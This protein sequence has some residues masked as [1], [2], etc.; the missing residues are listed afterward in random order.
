MNKVCRKVVGR[1]KGSTG[2]SPIKVSTLE[3]I[4]EYLD[5]LEELQVAEASGIKAAVRVSYEGSAFISEPEKSL[6]AVAADI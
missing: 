3:S 1:C 5:T 2:L 4:Q 6:V